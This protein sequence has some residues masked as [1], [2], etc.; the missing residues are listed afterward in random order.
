MDQMQ[1]WLPGAALECQYFDTPV[2]I[3]DYTIASPT[4][5]SKEGIH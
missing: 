4:K 1:K 5:T 3:E 2:I